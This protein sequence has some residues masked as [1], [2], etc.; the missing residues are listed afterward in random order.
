MTPARLIIMYMCID[1]L[2]EASSLC[3]AIFCVHV[4]VC[5]NSLGMEL[6]ISVL[7][8]IC[9]VFRLSNVS[10]SLANFLPMY[11]VRQH[12]WISFDIC[13]CSTKCTNLK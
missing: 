13:V 12:V 9:R 2:H 10:V 1:L 3:T 8:V 4:S 7:T 5:L 6:Y 11:R